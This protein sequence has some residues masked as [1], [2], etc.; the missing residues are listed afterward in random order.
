MRHGHLLA[1]LSPDLRQ[2]IAAAMSRLRPTHKPVGGN[3]N[4]RLHAMVFG[5]N[6]RVRRWLAGDLKVDWG[7]V[8]LVPAEG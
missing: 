8:W 1:A 6:L 3:R 5:R 2:Y 4:V 7:V